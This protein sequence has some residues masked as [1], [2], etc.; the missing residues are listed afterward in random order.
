MHAAG[1]KHVPLSATGNADVSTDRAAADAFD[2]TWYDLS[3]DLDRQRTPELRGFVTIHGVASSTIP[4]I[5]LD[6]APTMQV[7][8]VV[9]DTGDALPFRHEGFVLWVDAPVQAGSEARITVTYEGTPTSSGLG[10]WG[11]GFLASKPFFWSLSEPYGARDWWPN[12]DHP[13]DKAD[14]VRVA[15]RVP[16]PAR[17]GSNG[18][19]T[20][21]VPNG[22]GTTTWVWTHRYPIASYLVSLAGGAYDVFEQVYERP[23]ALVSEFGPLSLPIVHYV[24]AGGGAFEGVNHFSGWKR[25]VDVMPVLEEWYGPYPFPDE[26]Y[27]HAQVTFGGGMEHQTMSSLGNMGLNLVTH[28]LAHQWYGDK[29][30]LASWVDLWLNEGF[31]TQSEFLFMES[32]RAEYA[33][34]Y[35]QLFDLYYSRALTA[36]GTLV[37]SDTTNESSMFA[38]SRVYG[39]G[40]MVLRML[41]SLVGDDTYRE[42]LRA[43]AV[44]D[45]ARTGQF[46][47]TAERL[48]GLDLDRFFRD[49]V[50]TG[51]GAP[52]IDVSWVDASTAQM[53]AVDVTVRQVQEIDASNVDAFWLPAWLEVQIDGQH[54]RYR[55][56]ITQREQTLRIE[57]PGPPQAVV[58]DPDRWTL[59]RP[60]AGDTAHVPS[61]VPQAL[62]VYPNPATT[63]VRVQTDLPT[64]IRL[65]DLLGRRVRTVSSDGDAWIS[66]EGLAAGVY[67]VDSGS[68]RTKLIVQKP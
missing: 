51:T 35:R 18:L 8:S 27:G 50:F 30:G 62:S 15:V 67:F 29:V 20:A 57:L 56:D 52:E 43:H 12:D 45:L 33:T 17:V 9:N 7:I 16:D 10:S 13:S 66:L 49:W 41:R 63:H 21:V 23:E 39:K 54:Y 38:F 24:Y 47:E 36:P 25:V 34:E 59:W 14:S 55:A 32:D 11:S 5:R 61:P 6:L 26:K 22:D 37:L 31:A 48:S 2:I 64:T 53:H 42:I 46:Q 3:L 68:L 4:A 65:F 28:E 60:A 44:S 1:Q 19:L 40:W 58:F